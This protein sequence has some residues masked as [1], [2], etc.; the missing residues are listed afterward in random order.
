MKKIK[1]LNNMIYILLLG[2]FFILSGCTSY[3]HSI[4]VSSYS[5]N[6]LAGNRYY[7][8]VSENKLKDKNLILQIQEFEKYIDIVLQQ[9]G[10]VK[11]KNLK[12]ANQLIIFD[13]DIS[14]PQIHTY[15]YDE[16]VWDTV[17]RPYT[18]YRKIDWR[19]YPYTYWDRDYELIGYRTKIRTKTLYTKNIS[20]TSFSKTKNKSF[21]QVN[22]SM[23]DTSSDLRYSFPFLVKGISSYIGTDSGQV[24]N[25]TI[26][27]DDLD[28]EMMRR[29]GVNTSTLAK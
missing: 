8:E 24:I 5:A 1:N 12:N 2:I 22:G 27:D 11:S 13:Y 6:V 21:W 18:R 29:E 7:L 26:P 15:S 14:E 20:I 16:P 19:Y 25:I 4:Q 28:V 17:L 3:R 23:T 9:K 10:Y